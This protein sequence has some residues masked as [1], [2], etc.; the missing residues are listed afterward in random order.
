MVHNMLELLN[1]AVRWATPLNRRARSPSRSDGL[2]KLYHHVNP[3]EDRHQSQK[4]AFGESTPIA[5]IIIGIRTIRDL[6]ELRVY[7]PGG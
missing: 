2:H 1:N 4:S 5:H 3:K 6:Y 7:L